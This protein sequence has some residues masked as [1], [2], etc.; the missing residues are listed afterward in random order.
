MF[1][2]AIVCATAVVA[3]LAGRFSL[4]RQ[5]RTLRHQVRTLRRQRDAALY[6]ADHD[7]LTG[8]P[9][10]TLAEQLVNRHA[11]GHQPLVVVLLDL[12]KFKDINDTYGHQEGDRLLVA[13]AARLTEAAHR[14][15][16]TAARRSGD[17]F[18]LLLPPHPDNDLRH[19]EACLRAIATPVELADKDAVIAV[20]PRASA[21]VTVYDGRHGDVATALAQADVALY[22]A[23]KVGG[24]GYVRHEPTMRMPTGT[25]RRGPRLRDRRRHNT[26]RFTPPPPSQP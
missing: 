15:G 5:V 24:G 12:D 11:T 8:L 19:V 16:G 9:N 6:R 3:Y 17:E 26:G 4:R 10:R 21:G 22:H 1:I 7:A 20:V 2:L 14:H 18:L 25:P 13:V 23:K